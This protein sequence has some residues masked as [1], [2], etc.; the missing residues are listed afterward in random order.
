M[1]AKHPAA[2]AHT[3]ASRGRGGRRDPLV[4]HAARVACAAT[5]AVALASCGMIPPSDLKPPDLAFSSLSID[6]VSL[7]RIRFV[8]YVDTFNPNAVDIPLRDLRFELSLL[9]RPLGSGTTAR[10]E[11]TLPA[12][13]SRKLPLAMTVPT[14]Q[15]LDLVRRLPSSDWRAIPYRVSGSAYWGRSP[16][17]RRFDRSG[18]I[19]VPRALQRWW[20]LGRPQP[21]PVTL[22][23]LPPD[24]T[25]T[26][27][28]LS[29]GA[30]AAR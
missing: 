30:D 18:L 20:P 15:V 28:S 25:P 4:R 9:D 6:E 14:S 10:P 5:V 24:Q 3:G 23:P 16:F 27:M 29:D 12:N 13:G 17:E 19:D 1:E 2:H 26:G 7:D 21:A 8:A 22:G 11:E